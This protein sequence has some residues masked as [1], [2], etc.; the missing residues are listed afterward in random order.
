MPQDE[1]AQKRDAIIERIKQVFPRNPPSK[2]KKGV[3]ITKGRSDYEE[4]TLI[5]AFEGKRWEEMLSYPGLVYQMS[6]VDF[7]RVMNDK[8]YRY[9]LPAFL[10]ATLNDSSRWIYIDHP[11]LKIYEFLR[12]CSLKEL[13]VLIAYF[14]YQVEYRRVHGMRY[15]E[16][17]E[18]MLLQL[19]FRRDEVAKE[20][21]K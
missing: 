7:T 15:Q 5:E 3:N 11:I 4:R 21:A 9:F 17:L 14:D 18:N 6:D 8:A 10:I 19:M 13:D 20:Q 2:G 1:L 16:S 12:K